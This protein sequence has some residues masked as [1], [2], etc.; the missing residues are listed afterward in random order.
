[1]LS[2]DSFHIAFVRSNIA[3]LIPDAETIMALTAQF[4]EASSCES[5]NKTDGYSFTR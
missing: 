3:L 5:G 1:M 2:F 4:K